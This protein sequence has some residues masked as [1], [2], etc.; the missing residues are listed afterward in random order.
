MLILK[1]FG[2]PFGAGLVGSLFLFLVYLG[3]VSWAES[4][5]HALDLFW[6]DRW[7]VVPILTGFGLQVALYTILKKGYY[8]PVE[9]TGPSGPLMGAGGATSTIAMVACCAHHVTDVLPILG[10]TAAATFLARYRIPFMLLGLG[11]TVA[12]ILFMLAILYQARR[13]ALDTLS[14]SSKRVGF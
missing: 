12:G 11:T 4:P 10:M 9:H 14:Y 8:L 13:K 2:W 6:Q 7:I 5:D 3:I 1:R